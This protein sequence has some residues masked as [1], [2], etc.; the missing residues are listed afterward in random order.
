MVKLVRLDSILFGDTS[1]N[2]SAVPEDPMKNKN[3]LKA[4]PITHS[5]VQP[6]SSR[7]TRHPRRGSKNVQYVEKPDE[8]VLVIKN[9]SNYVKNIKPSASGPSDE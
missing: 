4:G 3:N 9:K 2:E 7:T 1:D 6:N 8:N 5:R